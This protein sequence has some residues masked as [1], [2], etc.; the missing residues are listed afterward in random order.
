VA[1]DFH[2][3]LAQTGLEILYL[4]LNQQGTFL[5]AGGIGTGILASQ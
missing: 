4:G 5:K 2:K 3:K 1:L